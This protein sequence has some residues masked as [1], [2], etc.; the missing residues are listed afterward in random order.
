MSEVIVV[1]DKPETYCPVSDA[2]I[3]VFLLAHVRQ[4]S[5]VQRP[6]A[7]DCI[8]KVPQSSTVIVAVNDVTA[9][10]ANH[11][12]RNIHAAS[13]TMHV[14]NVPVSPKL[15]ILDVLPTQDGQ[16]QIVS[17]SWNHLAEVRAIGPDPFLQPSFV[18]ALNE[19]FSAFVRQCAVE[20]VEPFAGKVAV[21]SNGCFAAWIFVETTQL[22]EVE[23]VTQTHE[24]VGLKL[25]GDS[26]QTTNARLALERNVS[27][28]TNKNGFHKCP[29]PEY[30]GGYMWGCA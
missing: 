5:A 15:S 6:D 12:H 8:S 14:G 3:K 24:D 4:V 19:N 16:V 7:R 25:F 9:I 30:H 18:I 10:L 1:L 28:R 13:I 26:N 11:V 23:Q 22:I 27:I 17:K 20:L 29:K 21:I 2:A